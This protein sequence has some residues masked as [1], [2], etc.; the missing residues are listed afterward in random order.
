MFVSITGLKTEFLLQDISYYQCVEVRGTQ[1]KIIAA[2]KHLTNPNAG[3][4]QSDATMEKT[5]GNI[6]Y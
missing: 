4:Y 5:T 2:V 1:D 6:L 3:N